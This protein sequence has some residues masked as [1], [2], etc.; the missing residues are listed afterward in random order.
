MSSLLFYGL[1]RLTDDP[2]YPLAV[3]IITM[4]VIVNI[5]FFPINASISICNIGVIVLDIV[6][7]IFVIYMIFKKR[8]SN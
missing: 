8:K 7:I 3:I 6:L 5:L 1:Y 2:G 4:L